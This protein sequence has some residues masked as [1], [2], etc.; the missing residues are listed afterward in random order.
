LLLEDTQNIL[1][2]TKIKPKKIIFYLPALWK[3]EAY[4]KILELSVETQPAIGSI[5][6]LLMQDQEMRKRG[7][8]VSGFVQKVVKEVSS[9]PKEAR[10]MRLGIGKLDNLSLMA[11]AKSFLERELDSEIQ[12]FEEDDPAIYDPKER[13]SGS[14]PFRPAIFVE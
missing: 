1:R 7:K 13:A 5:I 10:Q 11:D 14:L 3:N 2:V 4:T 9:L 6:N 12:F 8:E